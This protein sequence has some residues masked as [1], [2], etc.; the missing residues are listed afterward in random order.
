MINTA[1]YLSHKAFTSDL[2]P[3]FHG[4]E[5]QNLNV[6][7]LTSSTGIKMLVYSTNT[8]STNTLLP[9]RNSYIPNKEVYYLLPK[10]SPTV[11]KQSHE[12]L[13]LS[14]DPFFI[15]NIFSLT[16]Y[17]LTVIKVIFI[18]HAI[19]VECKTVSGKLGTKICVRLYEKKCCL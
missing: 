19:Y 13:V 5:F 4:D 18:R 15:K 1:S 7:S 12:H 11:Q 2:T 8:H 3:T 9:N 14:L 17:P 16:G 6:T 10:T